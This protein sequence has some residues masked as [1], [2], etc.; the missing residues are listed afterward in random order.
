MANGHQQTPVDIAHRLGI[1]GAVLGIGLY[2]MNIGA[3]V[4]AADEK[5]EDAQ[6]VEEKQ[7]QLILDVNTIQV[8]QQVQTKAIEANAKA[9][10][11]SKDEILDAIQKAT[12]D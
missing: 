2:V 5:F 9:I 7:D 4:G 8:T 3:W 10:E 11:K 6:T 12:E 1:W